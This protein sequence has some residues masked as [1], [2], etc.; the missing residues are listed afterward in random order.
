MFTG[1]GLYQG[2]EKNMIYTIVTRREMMILRKHIYDVDPNAFI[3]VIDS[4]EI[5]GQG[6]KSLKE[7]E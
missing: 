3:N 2:K 7:E 4:N 6:F 1:K 5:L